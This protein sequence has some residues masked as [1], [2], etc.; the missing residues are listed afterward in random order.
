[1]DDHVN[2][3]KTIG[4]LKSAFPRGDKGPITNQNGFSRDEV[5]EY[6]TALESLDGQHVA[7]VRRL[8]T[9]KLT[10][11]HQKV[12]ADAITS[13]LTDDERDAMLSLPRFGNP[14]STVASPVRNDGKQPYRGVGPYGTVLIDFHRKHQRQDDV[15][16]RYTGFDREIAKNPVVDQ[17]FSR[18]AEMV[19]LLALDGL[20]DAKLQG[21]LWFQWIN[22]KKTE[23]R[24]TETT[25]DAFPDMRYTGEWTGTILA[26]R[27]GRSSDMTDRDFWDV[28][29]KRVAPLLTGQGMYDEQGIM[30]PRFQGVL[31]QHQAKLAHW[32]K[33]GLMLGDTEK[34]IK[35]SKAHA[36]ELHLQRQHFLRSVR[37]GTAGIADADLSAFFASVGFSDEEIKDAQT[38]PSK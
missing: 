38:A 6:D 26:S 37:D 35:Q 5:R 36:A 17:R 20:K 13:N 33:K 1:V 19:S 18:N 32:M 7:L 22:R 15:L 31:G 29:V 25:A 12:L 21:L 28:K 16:L 4:A 10:V 3:L 27:F 23:L 30:I 14:E 11:K 2:S 9:G 8:V 34:V 24:K